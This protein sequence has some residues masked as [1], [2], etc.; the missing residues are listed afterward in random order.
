MIQKNSKLHVQMIKKG[1]KIYR[2]LF[3]NLT[4]SIQKNDTNNDTR[5]K[6]RVK[7]ILFTAYIL[8]CI[9]KMI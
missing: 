3:I 6:R 9:V 5:E 1:G 7:T 8:V 4:N 2:I